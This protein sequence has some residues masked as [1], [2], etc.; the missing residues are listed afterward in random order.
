MC[1]LLIVLP[2]SPAEA[3]EWADFWSRPDQRAVRALE[4]GDMLA[5]AEQFTDP[6]WK[7]AANYR[8]GRFEDSLAALDGLDGPEPMYN[9]GNAFARLGRYDEAIAAYENVL[10]Q[11]SAHHDASYNRDLLLEQM[12]Q[13][14]QQQQQQNEAADSDQSGETPPD[15]QNQSASEQSPGDQ[16]QDEASMGDA[17]QRPEETGTQ[18]EPGDEQDIKTDAQQAEVEAADGEPDDASTADQ[19]PDEDAQATEQWLRKIPDDP[20]GLLRRKFFYQYR[21]Q[22][23]R[24]TEQEPW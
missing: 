22:D 2:T 5:A 9:R 12:K 7:G 8:A 3:F 16:Q 1:P 4:K 19:P 14:Q 11:D 20:G 6:A 24:P 21:Q 23:S 17:G 13:Q 15:A 18:Q 10:E